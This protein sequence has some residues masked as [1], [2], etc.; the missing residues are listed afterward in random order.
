[1]TPTPEQLGIRAVQLGLIS[2]RE[3]QIVW[4]D[5]GTK[6]VEL[7]VFVNRLIGRELLTNYQV[8]RLKGGH[9]T[10]FFFGDYKVLYL[11]GRGTF[12]RVYRAISKKGEIVAVKVLRSKF[13]E[14]PESCAQFQREGELGKALQHPNIISIKEVHSQGK[15][16]FI[17]MEFLEGQSLRDFARLRGKLKLHEVVPIM[18]DVSAGLDFAFQRGMTHRDLKMSNVMISSSGTAKLADFGFAAVDTTADNSLDFDDVTIE[19]PNPRTLDYAALEKVTGVKKDDT[20][21]DIF[22]AGCI[23]YHLIAGAPPLSE[24][25]DRLERLNPLRFQNIIPIQMAVPDVPL[26]LAMIVNKAMDLNVRKRYQTPAEMY[27]DVRI[28]EKQMK[29][30]PG[31]SFDLHTFEQNDRPVRSVMV[32]E[33][34]NQL[35]EVFRDSLKKMGYRVLMI[36]DPQRAMNRLY[37]D[38]SVA[39]CVLVNAQ[40]IGHDAVDMF[41]EIKQVDQK[42]KRLPAILLLAKNQGIWEDDAEGDAVREVVQMPISMKQL[43]RTIAGL[44]EE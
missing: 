18:R 10:G 30:N 40:N 19:A 29:D 22:F 43:G 3:L 17:I 24:T 23:F 6:S 5:I 8:E 25:K 21:S 26:P 32:V 11:V 1:M 39:D 15:T 41:N 20:R 36:S 28:L 14:N 2:E 33:K 27:R 35:Q 16:H 44:L 4:S 31:K 7:E 37:D 13:S 34:D 12:A 9:T 38:R 42:G